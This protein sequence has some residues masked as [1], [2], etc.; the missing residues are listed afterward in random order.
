MKEVGFNLIFDKVSDK[1]GYWLFKKTEDININRIDNS[2]Y[3]KKS[4]LVEGKH[5]N[6]FCILFS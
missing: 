6:N 4:V 3:K 2:K 5:L 1:L